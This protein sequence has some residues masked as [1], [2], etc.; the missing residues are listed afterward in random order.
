MEIL[1]VW[2]NVIQADKWTQHTESCSSAHV[3]TVNVR[4]HGHS[5]VENTQQL[6]LNDK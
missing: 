1:N 2:V 4:T 6:E 5:V 3:Y